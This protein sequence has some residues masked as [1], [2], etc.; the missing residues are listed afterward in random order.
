MGKSKDYR[1]FNVF[2]YLSADTFILVGIEILQMQQSREYR[3]FDKVGYFFQ[4]PS[5]SIFLISHKCGTKVHM[6]S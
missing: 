6:I 4:K 3:G 5:T 1:R 2:C